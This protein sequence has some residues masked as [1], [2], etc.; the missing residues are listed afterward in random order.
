[1]NFFDVTIK[2]TVI[3]TYT[4]QADDSDEAVEIAVAEFSVLADDADEHYEQ[5]VLDIIELEKE[6]AT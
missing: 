2:A 1:M 5:E 3:K 4:V 6:Q